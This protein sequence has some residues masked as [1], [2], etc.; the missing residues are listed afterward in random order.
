MVCDV[1]VAQHAASLKKPPLEHIGSSPRPL[2]PGHRVNNFFLF[3]IKFLTFAIIPILYIPIPSHSSEGR[4][5]SVVRCWGGERWP[6]GV[7]EIRRNKPIGGPSR[8]VPAR[9]PRA[10][11]AELRLAKGAEAFGRWIARYQGHPAPK[12]RKFPRRT[13]RNPAAVDRLILKQEGA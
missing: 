3:Q 4:L 5:I 11:G 9:L 1:P 10:T 7:S 6:V 2:T 12:V 13:Q 8:L